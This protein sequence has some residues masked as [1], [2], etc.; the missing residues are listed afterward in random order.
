VGSYGKHL[1]RRLSRQP[2]VVIYDFYL[3][4][5]AQRHNVR[6]QTKTV[7]AIVLLPGMDGTGS[8]FSEFI[9]ALPHGLEPIVVAYPIDRALDYADLVQLARESLPTDRPYLLVGESFSGP[10]AISLAASRPEGLRGLVLVCSFARSPMPVPNA[11]RSLISRLPVKL[12]PNWITA[13]F[14]PRSLCVETAP[15]QFGRCNPQD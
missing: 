11:L 6:T 8:L 7:A 10:I 12:I 15:R 13:A 9:A 3:L 5:A 4:I 1:T 2:D 14:A